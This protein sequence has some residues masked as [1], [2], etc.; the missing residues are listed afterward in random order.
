M[1]HRRPASGAE[2][3]DQPRQV[4]EDLRR[5]LGAH[6]HSA[7]G[8]RVR[9]S[10]QALGRLIGGSDAWAMARAVAPQL[11]E[12]DVVFCNSESVGFPLAAMLR[13]RAP[14][15]RVAVFVHNADRPR[16]RLAMRLLRLRSKIDLHLACSDSQVRFLRSYLRLPEGA[17]RFVYDTTDTEFFT[18]GE[19]SPHKR[20]PVIAAV[21]LE[22]RDYRLLAQ[23]TW[24]LDLD[25]RISTFSADAVTEVRTL[26]DV[27]PDN[28]DRRFYSWPEL[29]QLYR[30]ADVVVVPLFDNGY[31]AGV[32]AVMEAQ[33]CGRPVIV[34]A[35]HGLSA[36]LGEEV[37]AVPPTSVQALREAVLNHLAEPEQA[38]RR[39]ELSRHLAVDRYSSKRYVSAVE[40][41]LRAL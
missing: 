26:P 28:M 13:R 10:D 20:R 39:A 6:V 3:D 34:T 33:S 15:P 18:P 7:G 22:Q 29:V 27:L 9:L 17:A 19:A 37:V 41:A 31:A 25:V 24:D 35:T 30:T 16:A 32:Q 4:M 5:R 14:R 38:R 11:G 1:L 21:G 8:R 12:Q 40:E 2:L 36:Y 23:A